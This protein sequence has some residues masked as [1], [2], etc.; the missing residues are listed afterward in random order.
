LGVNDALAEIESLWLKKQ[1]ASPDQF[2]PLLT[3]I[4]SR[5]SFMHI[6]RERAARLKDEF[7]ASPVAQASK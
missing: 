7:T 2:I 1:L 3:R 6:A 5:E 4:A